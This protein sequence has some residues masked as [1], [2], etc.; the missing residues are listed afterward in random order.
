[1]SLKLTICD[2]N[3]PRIN[4]ETAFNQSPGTLIQLVT[5]ESSNSLPY[6]TRGKSCRQFLVNFNFIRSTFV[7]RYLAAF[8]SGIS[9]L[10]SWKSY[11]LKIKVAVF[12]A[13][14][15]VNIRWD[16]GN[17]TVSYGLGSIRYLWSETL[18]V[19]PRLVERI[20]VSTTIQEK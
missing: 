1:M 11:F 5:S 14:K 10:L 17:K 13:P 4:E 2:I 12:N 16:L 20:Q 19:N 8:I 6:F 18:E 3:I 9:F 7:V 15:D